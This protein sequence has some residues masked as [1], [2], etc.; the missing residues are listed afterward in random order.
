MVT[1]PVDRAF[2]RARLTT[3][4]ARHQKV[5]L[6][7]EILGSYARLRWRL[8][9]RKLPDV[10]ESIRLPLEAQRLERD[11]LGDQL[12][13]VRLGRAVGRTLGGVPADA[14]CL[15]RSLVLIDMLARRGIEASFVIGVRTG[16]EFEAHAWV[17]KGG[18]PL[19][20]PNDAEYQRLVEL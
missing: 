6:A 14:P 10:L 11:E 15:V 5:T 4:F 1:A 9:R 17:E 18:L 20:P 19:L 3:P 16:P 12:A 7:L 13:G 8:T 2:V